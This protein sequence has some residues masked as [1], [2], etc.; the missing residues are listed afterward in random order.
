MET[1]TINRSDSQE[2]VEPIIL[3]GLENGKDYLMY[4]KNET[5]EDGKYKIY[6]SEA[7]KDK[8]EFDPQITGA[9]HIAISNVIRNKTFSNIKNIDSPIYNVG[10][11]INFKCRMD[12][13]DKF[14]MM[15]N[16]EVKQVA[17]ELVSTPVVDTNDINTTLIDTPVNAFNITPDNGVTKTTL[18]EPTENTSEQV[19]DTTP[20]VSEQV[21]APVE[22]IF[23]EEPAVEEKVEETASPIPEQPIGDFFGG[24]VPTEPTVTEPVVENTEVT[25]EQPVVEETQVIPE[26]PVVEETTTPVEETI[27]TEPVVQEE[28]VSEPITETPVADVKVEEQPLVETPI[29]EETTVTEEPVVEPATEEKV[30]EPVIQEEVVTEE[31][32]EEPQVTEEHATEAVQEPVFEDAELDALIQN[33]TTEVSNEDIVTEEQYLKAKKDLETT[34]D[35]VNKFHENLEIVQKYMNQQLKG[36]ASIAEEETKEVVKSEEVTYPSISELNTEPEELAG[37][38]TFFEEQTTDQLLSDEPSRYVA[39]SNV[40]TVNNDVELDNID[41]EVINPYNENEVEK[42]TKSLSPEMKDLNP[43]NTL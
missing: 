15:G 39:N 11:F 32:A 14:K 30:E 26:T 4:F 24:E 10:P 40:E 22:N 21:E 42:Y 23:P 25:P 37:D 13:I 27:V 6:V 8:T 36:I 2:T 35:Y 17:D 3:F 43:W 31:I 18:V 38:S 5:V 9:E 33:N 7:S 41:Q 28:V 19:I 34:M 16:V 1:L 29:I 12:T 20:V